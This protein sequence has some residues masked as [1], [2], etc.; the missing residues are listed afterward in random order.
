MKNTTNT[1]FLTDNAFV[2]GA[3]FVGIICFVTVG[4]HV[5]RKCCKLQANPVRVEDNELLG[6]E[7]KDSECLLSNPDN[8]YKGNLVAVDTFEA[9][10]AS[11]A[12][13]EFAQIL[14]ESQ[15]KVLSGGFITPDDQDMGV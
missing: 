11:L 12:G 10:E 1:D 3:V 13:N 7:Q 5:I 14:E 8:M 15:S 6:L 9:K 4:V 2:S